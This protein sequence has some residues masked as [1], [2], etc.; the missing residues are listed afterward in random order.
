LK[1]MANAK[2]IFFN[3][4]WRSFSDWF[5]YTQH[6]HL[7]LAMAF[8]FEL[9]VLSPFSPSFLYHRSTSCWWTMAFFL[10]ITPSCC[11]GKSNQWK[12]HFR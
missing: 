2:S 4:Q 1:L 5:R 11:K 7:T 6:T 10:S 3:W 12:W 9:P 8:L